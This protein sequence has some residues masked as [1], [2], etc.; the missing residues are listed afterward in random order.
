MARGSPSGFPHSEGG[1]MGKSDPP[2][3]DDQEYRGQPRVGLCLDCGR[4]S[5]YTWEVECLGIRL[6]GFHIRERIR[7]ATWP[8]PPRME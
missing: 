3:L 1:D 2:P 4:R 7:R 6:C 5:R 8:D